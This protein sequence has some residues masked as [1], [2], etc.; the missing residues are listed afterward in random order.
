VDRYHPGAVCQRRPAFAKRSDGCRMGV[1]QS[2]NHAVLLIVRE[3]MGREAS[4]SAG[5]I[6]NHSVKTAEVGGPRRYDA[7]KKSRAGSGTSS[8]IHRVFWSVPSSTPPMS[9]TVTVRPMCSPGTLAQCERI[10]NWQRFPHLPRDKQDQNPRQSG[11]ESFLRL[12]VAGGR[13]PAAT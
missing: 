11:S 7:G 2:I 8:S 13:S 5:V 4:P 3:T 6:D 10:M 9:R 12:Q 1:W